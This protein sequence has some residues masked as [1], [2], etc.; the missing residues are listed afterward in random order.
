MLRKEPQGRNQAVAAL[1]F[2][3]LCLSA[4]W[5]PRPDSDPTVSQTYRG[6]RAWLLG[7]VARTEAAHT[8]EN[9]QP[10]R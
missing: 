5:L 7:T 10:A 2:W 4:V 6:R 9:A 8:R 3:F 1:G